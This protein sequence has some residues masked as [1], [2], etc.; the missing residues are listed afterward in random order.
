[1]NRKYRFLLL[2]PIVIIIWKSFEHLDLFSK[3]NLEDVDP[4]TISKVKVSIYYEA[5]CPDSKFFILY[6]MLPVYEKLSD[7]IIID[8]VPYGKA[9]VCMYIC[10]K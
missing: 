9:K 3:N 7:Y 8:F 1:M 4:G 6:Q 5:L 2:F 10:C